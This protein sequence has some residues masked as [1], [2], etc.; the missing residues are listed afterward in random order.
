MKCCQSVLLAALLCLPAGCAAS[1]EEARI[2]FEQRPGEVVIR[3]GVE[4]VATYVYND[5]NILRPYFRDVF[6]PGAIQ[7]TR[8]HPPREGIDRMDHATMHPGL[9]LAFGDLGGADFWR[10]QASVEHMEFVEPPRSQT[11]R[12]GF[13]VRNRYVAESRTVCEET[14]EYTFLI[15]P[16]GYVILW[17]ST[18]QSR[19]SS[20]SFGDQEEMGL[21]VRVATPIAVTGQTGGRIFDAEQ[22]RGEK[23]IRGRTAAWCDYSGRV[24]ERFVGIAI[25]PDPGNFR[26]SWWHVR[27]YGLMVANPFARNTLGKGEPSEVVVQPGERCRLRWAIL[28]H[29]SP[30][31]QGVDIQEAYHDC[32]SL[33]G[34]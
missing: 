12:G 33:L 3:A 26:S 21:G 31:E 11:G 10:N 8:H 18:F 34:K 1:A 5:P 32:I 7:V 13:V 30:T 9:F 24:D 6:A 27:D 4:P 17:D 25:M 16:Q 20:F 29:R 2:V 23:E 22:R 19:G 28:L 15:R 14:C